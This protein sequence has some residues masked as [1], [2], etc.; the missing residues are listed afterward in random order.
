V[1]LSIFFI[2]FQNDNAFQRISCQDSVHKSIIDG[3]LFTTLVED[4]FT[5]V[6]AQLALLDEFLASSDLSMTDIGDAVVADALLSIFRIIFCKQLHYGRT[7]LFLRDIE[8]CVARAND[9]WRMGEKTDSLMQGISKKH[10]HHL[11]LKAEK[12]DTTLVEWDIASDLVKEEASKLIDKMNSDAVEASNHVAIYIMRVIQQLDIPRELFSRHWEENLTNN[13]VAKY[14]LRVY[15]KYLADIKYVLVSDCLYHKVLITLA[16][17][18]ICFYLKCFIFKASRIRS[19][20]LWYDN[21]KDRKD[22]FRSQRRAL[23]RMTHDIEV[24]EDFFSGP[25]RRE[26]STYQNH[27]K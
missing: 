15:A 10:Y 11:T 13:E 24:F 1:F 2:K 25:F 4:V 3:S 20:N 6:H 9:Y 23:M 22:F 26:R 27:F 18:T 19:S 12:S 14:I 16:R 21:R 8:T 5:L 17:C 7:S